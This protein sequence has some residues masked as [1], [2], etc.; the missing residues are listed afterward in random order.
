MTKDLIKQ[1]PAAVRDALSEA[2]MRVVEKMDSVTEAAMWK[3]GGV[4]S[5][6]ARRVIRRHIRHHF[7]KDALSSERELM[8]L[9]KGHSPVETKS[10][11]YDKGDGHKK[12]TLKCSIKHM[13]REVEMQTKGKQKCKQKGSI[14][15]LGKP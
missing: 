4:K 15:T 13:A 12:E 5:R 14:G 6:T 3:D 11:E 7:G 8:E 9:S 1:D 10:V 2:G